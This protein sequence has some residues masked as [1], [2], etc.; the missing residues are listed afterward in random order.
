MF[1][2]Y[3]D[4]ARIVGDQVRR[5]DVD[6]EA[7]SM[8]IKPCELS[9]CKA[10]CCY[11]GVYL[12]LE[13]ARIIYQLVDAA[14]PRFEGY[15]LDL[16]QDVLM[17]ARDG[18]AIKTMVREAKPGELAKDFPKHFEKTRCVF[19]D[20][21]GRCGLQ[22][23]SMEDELGD[24]YLKPLTCWIHPIVILPPMNE[25]EVPLVTLVNRDNDPQKK[26]G[27]PGYGSC[28]HCGREDKKGMPAYQVL[29][30]EIKALGKLAGRDIHGEILLNLSR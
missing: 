18:R 16:P 26:E 1:S 5:A 23:M 11:D 6:H 9:R 8:L 20:D 22:R 12:G 24:W 2:I 29:E 19:L 13:E 15:G 10:T 30:A 14:R 3:K 17:S 21:L 25:R 4:T 27:Y 28:T 7:F